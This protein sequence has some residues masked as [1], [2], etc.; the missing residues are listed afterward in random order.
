MTE[1]EFNKEKHW[2]TVYQ[3]KSGD[4][5]SWY[6]AYPGVSMQFISQYGSGKDA[7]LID[8]GGGTSN[9]VD[10]LV[11]KGYEHV[12]V[13]DI[14]TVALEGAGERLGDKARQIEWVHSDI[15][16][17][18]PKEKYDIWHDRAAFHFLT[19]ERKVEHY[20]RL[21]AEAIKDGGLLILGT[22]SEKGPVEC[23]N[24]PVHRYSQEQL[25]ALLYAWFTKI[26]CI[27]TDHVTPRET[28]QNFTFCAFRRNQ[29]Q[30]LN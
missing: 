22:F 14:S 5:L 23:S 18:H 13:L 10:I 2:D 21:A 20:V 29:V 6:Q 27:N 16:E 4:Q 11:Q 7:H 15:L 25:E 19:E 1:I 8:I 9:L 28:L 3:N 12:A 30:A 24:L 17:F 26:E